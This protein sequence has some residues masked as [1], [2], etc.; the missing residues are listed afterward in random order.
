VVQ[1]QER[2][3]SGGWQPFGAAFFVLTV[4]RLQRLDRSELFAFFDFLCFFHVI[5]PVFLNNCGV[6]LSRGL[7]KPRL[8]FVT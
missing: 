6:R 7:P 1:Q 8:E 5:S 4:R 2:L 3:P